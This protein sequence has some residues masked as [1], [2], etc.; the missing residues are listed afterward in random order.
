MADNLGDGL[1]RKK[2]QAILGCSRSFFYVLLDKG[3]FP[4]A[5]FLG[6][7]LRVP[8][9]DVEAYRERNNLTRKRDAKSD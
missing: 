9:A 8:R 6:K 7:S 4:N 3:E 1:N 5:F 2:V